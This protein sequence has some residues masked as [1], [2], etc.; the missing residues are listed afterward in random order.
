MRIEV[1]QARERAGFA[2]NRA[3]RVCVRPMRPI[4]AY[5]AKLKIVVR[6]DLRFRKER[7]FRTKALLL[8][9][10]ADPID[11]NPAEIVADREEPG[12]ESLCP[13][14]PNVA[15][16]LF[17]QFVLDVDVLQLEGDDRPIAGT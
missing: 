16:V 15:R 1:G 3:N 6:R 11:E 2:E 14:G 12:R 13:L 5:S 7:V 17:N 9:Q 4:E 8:A 10:E